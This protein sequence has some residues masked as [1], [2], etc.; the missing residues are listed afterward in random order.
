MIRNVLLAGASTAFA[1][2]IGEVA[3]RLVRP[4][5]FPVHPAGM[6]VLDDA[7]GYALRPGF[8]GTLERAEFAAVFTTDERGLRTTTPR[9]ADP[10][11]RILAIGDSQTFGFGVADSSTYASR[12]A[13]LLGERGVEDAEVMN[14]GVPGYGT[15][16][17]RSFLRA[18]GAAL[19]PDI[20]L[21][22]FLPVN[23]FAESRTPA[24]QWAALDDGMLAHRDPA[25][26]PLSA[27]ARLRG[28]QKRNSHLATLVSENLG[29]LAMR[30]GWMPD[31]GGLLGENFT[32]QDAERVQRLI[33]EIA[34]I[35]DGLGARLLV[36]YTTSK[37]H[38][39]GDAYVEPPSRTVIE[40]AAEAAGIPWLDVTPALRDRDDRL[41]L[42]FR[43]DGHWSAAG[44]RAIA[45]IVAA[46]L[47]RLGW[48]DSA[49]GRTSESAERVR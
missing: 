7:V 12:L 15:A 34:T 33:A 41:E 19:A 31:R 11:L 10:R 14:A 21:L 39:I 47:D 13:L 38:V 25:S 45:E 37:A 48:L 2:G 4:Q 44:H 8:R 29:W 49:P 35:A 26:E 40:T 27:F 22:Q 9:P 23:D 46:E 30:A 18:R 3:V 28:W 6:Y 42:F 36:L 20:V 32:A 5:I 24:A 16:D 43:L 17:Q 1:L